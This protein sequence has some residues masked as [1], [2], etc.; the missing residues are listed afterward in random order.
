MF[1]YIFLK[2]S[3]LVVENE[4]LYYSNTYRTIAI[5]LVTDRDVQYLDEIEKFYETQ[6]TEMPSNIADIIGGI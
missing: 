3:D 4:V 1:C 2:N 5:N 6:I